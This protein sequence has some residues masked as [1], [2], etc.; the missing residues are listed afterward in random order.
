[1]GFYS[2]L[3]DKLD[4]STLKNKFVMISYKIPDFSIKA[5]SREKKEV[6]IKMD[7]Y[8]PLCVSAANTGN[9]NCFIATYNIEGNTYT[10]IWTNVNTETET[11]YAAYIKVLY[12]KN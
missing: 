5:R 6:N 7:G 11:T 10:G 1:M 8:T 12:V 3:D 9:G 4:T 2:N